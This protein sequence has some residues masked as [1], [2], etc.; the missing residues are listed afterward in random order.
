MARNEGVGLIDQAA[1]PSSMSVSV[2]MQARP[3]TSPWVD[4]I[5]TALA[6]TPAA[7]DRIADAAPTVIFQDAHS[8]QLL[9]A[10]FSLT[11]YPDQ[12]ESYYHNLMS[13]QPGCYVITDNDNPDNRPT[14]ERVTMSFDE[15]HAYLE[16]DSEIFAVPL[17]PEL[18]RWSE[19]YVLE[20]YCPEPK[21]KRKNTD[22]KQDGGRIIR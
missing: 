18:Y 4:E 12:C 3:A 13:P 10:G 2:I 6:I 19:Q 15:A 21:R 17:S 1:V 9:Y 16:G 11:L 22:W 14:P 8:R 20:H 7:T 5:W